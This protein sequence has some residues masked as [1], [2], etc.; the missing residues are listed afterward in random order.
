M[1]LCTPTR[2]RLPTIK[3][4]LLT[5]LSYD[6]I[7]DKLGVGHRTI[8]RDIK[9][10]LESGDFELWIKEEWIR[11]HNII[12]HDNPEEAYRNITK[13]V[14]KMLTQKLEKKVE[15][16]EKKIDVDIRDYTIAVEASIN[17]IHGKKN[18]T[19]PLDTPQ[20][21]SQTNDVPTTAT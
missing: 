6:Q 19:Q 11:L 16:T 1:A 2:E 9:R 21:T 18:P 17:Y 10:W 12:I 3:Q 7:A 14:A 4:G 20:T 8:D 15:I 13:L 5:G